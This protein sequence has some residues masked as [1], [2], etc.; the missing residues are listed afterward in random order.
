[1]PDKYTLPT[2]KANSDFATQAARDAFGKQYVRPRDRAF[3]DH[4]PWQKLGTV[5]DGIVD[6]L[7]RRR[8]P[9]ADSRFQHLVRHLHALGPRPVAEFLLELVA[10]DT[11]MMAAVQVSLERYHHLDPSTVKALGGDR[12]PAIPLHAVSEAGP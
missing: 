2:E 8:D 12:F 3:V 1:M 9:L 5:T 10:N 6:R 11:A 4:E 7:R